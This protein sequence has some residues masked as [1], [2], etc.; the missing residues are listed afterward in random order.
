MNV[1]NDI[2]EKLSFFVKDKEDRVFITNENGDAGES[3][4]MS[5]RD[6]Y[7]NLAID[8]LTMLKRIDDGE[9]EVE[10]NDS[11]FRDDLMFSFAQ[12]PN[13]TPSIFGAYLCKDNNALIDAVI[14]FTAWDNQIALI[15]NDPDF[16]YEKHQNNKI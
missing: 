10:I 7:L 14:K 8:I 5:T 16:R 1:L 4:M 3:F 13:D 6:G 12:L 15:K 2:I 9:Y 11:K